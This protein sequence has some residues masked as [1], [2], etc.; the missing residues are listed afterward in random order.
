MT[1]AFPTLRSSELQQ[2]DPNTCHE[3]SW[4]PATCSIS[5]LSAKPA[6]KLLGMI[7]S[8]KRALIKGVTGQDGAYLSELL[9]SQGSEVH[10][11]KRRDSLFNT[12]RNE[13]RKSTR[14]H[15]SH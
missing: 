10:G 13:D 9:L 12:D 5:H 1:H 15:S 8:R 3:S 6:S 14:R 11:V 4:L 7:M 2:V